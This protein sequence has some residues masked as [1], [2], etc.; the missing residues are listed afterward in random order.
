VDNTEAHIRQ[1]MEDTRAAMAAKIGMIQERLEET[2]DATGTSVMKIVNAVLEQVKR[3]QETIDHITSS[4]DMT[5]A[6][7]QDVT[8]KA[9]ASDSQGVKLTA[10]LYQRP[11]VMMSTAVLMG[12]IL[13][14]GSRS[15]SLSSS[16]TAKSTSGLPPRHPTA[17]NPTDN[18]FISPASSP[19]GGIPTPSPTH[20]ADRIGSSSPRS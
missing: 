16:V 7:A 11:W 2:V 6:H 19:V 20:T 5:I 8:N 13:G 4:V 14:S 18:S 9:I 15:A 12:Y 1:E 10:D 3:V 17:D